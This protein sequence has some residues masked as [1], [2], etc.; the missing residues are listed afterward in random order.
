MAKKAKPKNKL[1]S[2]KYAKYEVKEGKLLRKAT[3]PK[4]GPGMFLA[5]HKD[6]L[7]CGKCHYVEMKAKKSE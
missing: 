5:E 3:C 6:R 4:C 1:T 2:K 7:Y